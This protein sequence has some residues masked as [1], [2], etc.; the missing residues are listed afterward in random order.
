MRK[1]HLWN[2]LTISSSQGIGKL[3]HDVANA[4]VHVKK[5]KKNRE[6]RRPSM[7]V[8]SYFFF[9]LDDLRFFFY[10]FLKFFFSFCLNWSLDLCIQLLWYTL[11]VYTQKNTSSRSALA[12]SY[13]ASPKP[14][15]MHAL[16]MS[17]FWVNACFF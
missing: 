7:R 13:T 10:F 3:G 9:F 2:L 15:S 5:K 12:T 1:E 4:W 14:L 16:S 8:C 17:C 6:D 11:V